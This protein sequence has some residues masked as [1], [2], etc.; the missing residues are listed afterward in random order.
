MSARNTFIALA[1]V[2]V[3]ITAA[4]ALGLNGCQLPAR[5]E[6]A[7]EAVVEIDLDVVVMEG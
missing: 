6:L 5:G 1:L 7:E 3:A 2:K 4:V